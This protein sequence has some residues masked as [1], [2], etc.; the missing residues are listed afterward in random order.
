MYAD[1]GEASIATR[2][3]FGIALISGG[4]VLIAAHRILGTLV[5]RSQP[6]LLRLG[7]GAAR[8]RG[9]IIL[10]IGFGIAASGVLEIVLG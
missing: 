10:V 8:A 7:R 6:R 1:A 4:A 2:L 9:T 3:A 5:A